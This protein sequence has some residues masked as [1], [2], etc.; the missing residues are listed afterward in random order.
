MSELKTET[1]TLNMGPQHPSTHGVFR[2][3]LEV[4]G[5]HIVNAEPVMGY[6]HRGTEKLAENFLY[7]QFIPY[8]DRLDYMNAMTNNYIY[9]SAIEE[10]L[11][12][13]IPERAEYLR[14]ITMELN[15]IASHLVWWGTYL[16]DIGAMSPFLYAFRDRETIL[17]RLNEISGARMTFT[18]HRIGG[19]KWDAPDGWLAKVQETVKELHENIQEFHTLVTGNEI[20]QARTIGVGILSKEKV[21]NWGLSGP[22]ARG[23]GV[24]IDL[25]KTAPYCIYDRFDFDIPTEKEGD[26]YARYK[27]RVA[28]MFQSL[29]IIEQACE[30]I[31]E[32]EIITKKGKRIMMIKPPA[33]EVYRRV[34][35]SKGEIGVYAVSNGTNKPY[36]IKLRRPSFVNVSIL[37]DLLKGES[38]QNLVAIFGSLDVVL[39]E[40]D[41]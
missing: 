37:Q 23:S 40:V 16:L 29:R 24:N 25:R 22:I 15:R 18:Y 7:T 35:A 33:G 27:V 34:E 4:D 32:G 21:I 20:F 9:C 13:E 39:G 17:D 10:L 38:I 31:P 11:E 28:E 3:K 12:W 2:L 19:V 6:L 14:V 8:T 36:R 41:A 26:V 1:M 30:Q 5:E